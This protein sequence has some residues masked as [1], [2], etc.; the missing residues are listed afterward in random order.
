MMPNAAICGIYRITNMVNGK[1]YI[2]QSRNIAARWRQHSHNHKDTHND[3]IRKALIKYGA[4]NFAID[5]LEQCDADML[6]ELERKYIAQ[7]DS[8]S[9]NGYNLENGGWLLKK[10]S[11]E[12]KSKIS[13][14]LSRPVNQYSVS[15]KFIKTYPSAQ[16]IAGMTYREGDRSNIQMVCLGKKKTSLGFQWRYADE[17]TGDI[18]P[19]ENYRREKNAKVSQYTK[20]G[21]WVATFNNRLEASRVTGIS[22]KNIYCCMSKSSKSAGGFIWKYEEPQ[23]WQ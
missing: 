17:G 7:Y 10:L 16:V 8:L 12:T 19:I 9:P 11:K 1:V 22:A 6:D 18:S 23:L 3:H 2:G 21:R 13:V 20:D 15:G 14:A 5:I 4:E